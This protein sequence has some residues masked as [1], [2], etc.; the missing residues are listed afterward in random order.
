MY[1]S[2]AVSNTWKLGKGASTETDDI[3]KKNKFV[4]EEVCHL[5]ETKLN[6]PQL[7]SMAE[8]LIQKDIDEFYRSFITEVYRNLGFALGGKSIYVSRIQRR[9]CSW[10]TR[11]KILF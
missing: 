7:I 2:L 8:N 10:S 6:F 11:R 1:I 4:F 3:V 9:T 5:S